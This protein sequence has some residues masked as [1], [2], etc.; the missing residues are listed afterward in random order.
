[1]SQSKYESV[2]KALPKPEF[3]PKEEHVLDEEIYKNGSRLDKYQLKLS[4]HE[5]VVQA[6]TGMVPKEV[7]VN[8]RLFK[9][10][11]PQCG[12]SVTASQAIW[13]LDAIKNKRMSSLEGADGT[14]DVVHAK[15][16]RG[17]NE[18]QLIVTKGDKKSYI[19]VDTG[20]VD[21]IEQLVMDGLIDRIKS[22]CLEDGIYI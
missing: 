20:V 11:F 5:M 3:I 9:N 12:I 1:M 16:S 17:D 4:V 10:N 18:Y 22:I 2:V 14:V 6:S 19:S 13:L 8:I 7:F 21:K 15:S